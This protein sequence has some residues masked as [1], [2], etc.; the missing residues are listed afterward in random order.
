MAKQAIIIF[1]KRKS[2]M[3]WHMSPFSNDPFIYSDEQSLFIMFNWLVLKLF[4]YVE[5]VITHV[6]GGTIRT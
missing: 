6:V 1:R 5:K 4:M 3:V 2:K